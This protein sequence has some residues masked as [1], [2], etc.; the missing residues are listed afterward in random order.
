MGHKALPWQLECSALL[1]MALK[2]WNQS[3]NTS[4][5][6]YPHGNNILAF[7]NLDPYRSPILEDT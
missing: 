2:L 6:L 3:T 7:S 1:S 4:M 5:H